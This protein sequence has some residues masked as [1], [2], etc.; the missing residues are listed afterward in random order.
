M[1]PSRSQDV[2]APTE[3]AAAARTTR[4]S[5]QLGTRTLAPT[6]GSAK[7]RS[8]AGLWIVLPALVALAVAAVAVVHFLRPPAVTAPIGP[9]SLQPA[10]SGAPSPTVLVQ[11]AQPPSAAP[12]TTPAPSAEAPVPTAVALPSAHPHATAATVPTAVPSSPRCKIVTSFD[13][14]G[15]KHFKQQCQ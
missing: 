12:T 11:P 9:A 3:L 1:S 6:I 14:D 10:V 4:S 15:N 7:D 8:R 13:A 2:K 5:P